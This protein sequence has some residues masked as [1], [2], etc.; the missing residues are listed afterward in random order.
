M[1]RSWILNASRSIE[2]SAAFHRVVK[3]PGCFLPQ[4]NN[5]FV[6]YGFYLRHSAITCR[7]VNPLSILISHNWSNKNEAPVCEADPS[8]SASASKNIFIGASDHKH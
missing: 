7:H 2:F 8:I 5:A 3:Q 1:R 4:E 6:K